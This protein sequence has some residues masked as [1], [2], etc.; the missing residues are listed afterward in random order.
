MNKCVYTQE[1]GV[2]LSSYSLFKAR[3]MKLCILFCCVAYKII[4]RLAYCLR[5]GPMSVSVL[6]AGILIASHQLLLFKEFWR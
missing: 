4:I 3:D 5:T 6:T 1:P 2:N